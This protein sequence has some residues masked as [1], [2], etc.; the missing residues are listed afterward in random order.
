[1]VSEETRER[2]LNVMRR[3]NYRPSAIARSLATKRTRTIGLIVSSIFNPFTGQ[4]VDG[5]SEAAHEL[6]CSLILAS[7]DY[8]GHDVP[9]HVETLLHQWVDGIFLASQPL[10]EGMLDQLEFGD[11]PLVI[12]DH[13]Q[14]PPA[15]A[16]GLVG[17]EWQRAGYLATRHL[18]EL[19]HRRIGYIGGIP[20]RSSTLLRNQGYCQALAEAGIAHLPELEVAGDFLTEG[21]Y[22]C[23]L[24]LLRQ[25]PRPSALV[26]ANDMMALGALQAANEL[27]LR[28]P[29]ELSV[30]GMDD[31]TFASYVAP[32]LTTVHVPT[33]ELGRR[34]M[35]ILLEAGT[36]QAPLQRLTLP[37][38]LII[39]R[40]TAA[41]APGLA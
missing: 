12:M 41:P 5:A 36:G 26:L 39:R 38:E 30:V 2:V 7:A 14:P 4:L 29:H 18:I 34:G 20:D 27:D 37:V 11:T 17:F 28:V 35:H 19:G 33:R 16:V 1:M 23:A 8:D 40:S 25:S 31:I 3:H 22:R 21:G 9:E 24:Q 13:G 10:P 32:P 6:D 15:N